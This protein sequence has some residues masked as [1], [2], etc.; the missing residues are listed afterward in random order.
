MILFWSSGK[1]GSWG[2]LNPTRGFTQKRKLLRWHTLTDTSGTTQNKHRIKWG[3]NSNT[4]NK[5]ILVKV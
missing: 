1:E 4:L 2:L 5:F 3:G